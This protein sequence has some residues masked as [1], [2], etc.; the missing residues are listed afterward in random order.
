MF[1]KQFAL[2]V[3][4]LGKRFV[5]LFL[6]LQQCKALHFANSEN[7]GLQVLPIKGEE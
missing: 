7:K 3:L 2:E 6:D 4:A 5:L 1:I